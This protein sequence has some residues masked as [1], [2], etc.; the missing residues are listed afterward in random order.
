[1]KKL[2]LSLAIIVFISAIVSAFVYLPSKYVFPTLMYHSIDEGWRT[3]KTSVSPES[4]ENQMSFLH[5]KK[6]KV[7]SL[8]EVVLSFKNKQ[9]LPGKAVSITFDDGY[10]NN[11]SIAYPVL[12]RYGFEAAIFVIV[13]NVGKPGYMNWDQLKRMADDGINIGSHT[14]THPD[15]RKLSDQDLKKEL[16]ESK[17]ILEENLKR[18]V[19]FFAYPG[20]SLDERVKNAVIEAGYKGACA[21]NPPRHYG[22]DDPY[23][24]KRVRISRTS[25]NLLV[26]RMESS[27]FYTFIKETRDEE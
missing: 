19:D 10:M 23:A 18:K 4:F 9:K 17:R 15:L 13:N 14:L 16:V 7:L 11:Y 24:V 3:E 20:G 27:G 25:N 5:R 12:R 1:M 6:Y 26:F 8:E 21:T 22:S 2:L